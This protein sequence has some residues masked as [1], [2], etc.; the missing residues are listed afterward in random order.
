MKTKI[1]LL[2]VLVFLIGSR[3]NV[4]KS[5][6]NT[7]KLS[8][9]DNVQANDKIGSLNYADFNIISNNQLRAIFGKDGI[10]TF[11]GKVKLNVDSFCVKG[12]TKTDSM[13][14]RGPLY[15]GDSSIQIGNDPTIVGPSRIRTTDG[16]M[17]FLRT[18]FQSSH[19]RIGAGVELGTPL[20]YKLSLFDRNYLFGGPA[21]AVFASFNNQGSGTFPGTGT[22]ANDG[23]LIGIASN[24]D[25]EIR[26]QEAANLLFSTANIERMMIVGYSGVNQGFIG[27]GNNFITPRSKLH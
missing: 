6:G 4:V 16:V 18:G 9:N 21:P 23:L 8:G 11:F 19:I 20:N 17:Y 27:M 1:V 12:F 26:Q 14:V 10:T 22:L 5:Q 2:I 13:R 7:V 24:T 3:N 25:A 15:V